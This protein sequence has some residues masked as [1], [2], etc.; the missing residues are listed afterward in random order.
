MVDDA[1]GNSPD[2][3]D[4]QRRRGGFADIVVT[5]QEKPGMEEGWICWAVGIVAAI[6]AILLAALGTLWWFLRQKPPGVA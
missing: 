6:I 1:K 3:A 4:G 2:R 5:V